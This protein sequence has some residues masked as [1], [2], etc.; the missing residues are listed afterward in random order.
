MSQIVHGEK[1]SNHND[2]KSNESDDI[3]QH[4]DFTRFPEPSIQ[5]Q[6]SLVRVRQSMQLHCWVYT[7]I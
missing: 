5:K 7:P 1:F 3:S 4:V 6:K 2:E